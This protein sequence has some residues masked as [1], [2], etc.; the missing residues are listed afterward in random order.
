VEPATRLHRR[1]F[2][3]RRWREGLADTVRRTGARAATVPK[4]AS[5]RMDTIARDGDV[6]VLERVDLPVADR[7]MQ[8]LEYLVAG[9]AA[10]AAIA[11]TFA[12]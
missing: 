5:E 10:L 6:T 8:I 12:R 4:G 9:L 2:G 11:L 1:T 3:Q 7:G